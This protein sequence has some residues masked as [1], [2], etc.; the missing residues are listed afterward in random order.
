M[1][2]V[3][4]NVN[5]LRRVVGIPDLLPADVL[6][7]DSGCVGASQE[8]ESAAATYTRS[9]RVSVQRPYRNRASDANLVQPNQAGL[10]GSL[11]ERS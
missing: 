5:V 6:E 7:I 8:L 3:I 2:S 4:P 9:R 11:A 10:C 1:A